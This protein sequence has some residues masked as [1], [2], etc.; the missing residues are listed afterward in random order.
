MIGCT[1]FDISDRWL[2]WMY[3]GKRTY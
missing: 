3:G 1:M 2:V